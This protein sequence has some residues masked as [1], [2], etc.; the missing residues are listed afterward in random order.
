MVTWI[1]KI[2]IVGVNQD[3]MVQLVVGGVIQINIVRI[4][5]QILATIVLWEEGFVQRR[6]VTVT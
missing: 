3:L 5:V 4:L 2:Q 6:M 1:A